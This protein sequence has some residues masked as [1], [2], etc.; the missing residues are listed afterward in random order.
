MYS[1]HT[2]DFS[3]AEKCVNIRTNLLGLSQEGF[4]KLLNVSRTSVYKWETGSRPAFSILFNIALECG[5]TIDYLYNDGYKLEISPYGLDDE[6]YAILLN[7]F[8]YFVLK[9]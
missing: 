7:L 3:F 8:D 5:F 6:G 1:N 2:P 9:K 4:S